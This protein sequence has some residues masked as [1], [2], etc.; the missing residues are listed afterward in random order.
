MTTV[1]CNGINLGSNEDDTRVWTADVSWITDDDQLVDAEDLAAHVAAIGQMMLGV[2][3]EQLAERIAAQLANQPVFRS[4]TVTVHMHWKAPLRTFEQLSATV[5]ANRQSSANPSA[6]AANTGGEESAS[7]HDGALPVDPAYHDAVISLRSAAPNAEQLFREVI[8]T[9]DSMPGNQV[10]G[11]S[12][13][14]FVGSLNGTDGHAAMIKLSTAMGTRQLN[15]VLDALHTAH[16]GALQLSVVAIGKAGD[17]SLHAPEGAA[18]HHLGAAVLEPWAAM[19]PNASYNGDPLAYL[20][21]MAPDSAQ[22]GVESEQWVMG[23]GR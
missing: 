10:D 12:P 6:A 7:T 23:G 2:P 9:L 13:L 16:E 18:D 22:V 20:L 4:V 21:A 8:V 19:V 17:E 3:V 5:A 11:I 14:Y 15:Q 1:D